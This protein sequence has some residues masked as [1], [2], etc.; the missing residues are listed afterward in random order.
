MLP[1]RPQKLTGITGYMARHGMLYGITI[2][3]S[4]LVHMLKPRPQCDGVR[5]RDLWEVSRS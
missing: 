3:A 4:A 2:A 5:K 1:H